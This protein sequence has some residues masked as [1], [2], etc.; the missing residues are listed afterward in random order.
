MLRQRIK[1]FARFIFLHSPLISLLGYYNHFR[2]VYR[3]KERSQSVFPPAP[4]KT[5]EY[6]PV[7]LIIH[8][9]GSLTRLRTFLDAIV[10]QLRDSDEMTVIDAAVSLAA[11]QGK[12]FSWS[13]KLVDSEAGSPGELLNAAIQASKNPLLVIAE[14]S[15]IPEAGFLLSLAGFLVNHPT[16]SF[17]T[18]PIE[19]QKR[20]SSLIPTMVLDEPKLLSYKNLAIWKK[21]WAQSGGF[22]ES[23]DYYTAWEI[24]IARIHDKTED[25]L[26]LPCSLAKLASTSSWMDVYRKSYREGLLGLSAESV[27]EQIRFVLPVI[28]WDI[29]SLVFLMIWPLTGLSSLLVGLFL[30]PVFG[31]KFILQ[32]AIPKKWHD[33]FAYLLAGWMQ[34]VRFFA[35]A[36]GVIRRKDTLKKLDSELI[37]QMRAIVDNHPSMQ[38]IVLF[39]PMVDWSYMFQRYQQM[40]RQFAKHGYLVF[41]RTDNQLSDAFVG[42][43]QVEPY[44]F[45]TP[46]P[47]ETFSEIEP[48]LLYFNSPWL[49][50]TLDCFIKPIVIYDH[51]DDIQVSGGRVADHQT[52]LDKAAVVLASSALLLDEDRRVRSDVLF[53]PNA[54]DYDLVI[55][56][57]PREEELPPDDLQPILAKNKPVVGYTG[58]LARWF[59]YELLTET[60]NRSPEW[61]FVLI[62]TDYDHSLQESKL[63]HCS[64]VTWLG[65]KSYE[66]LFRYT[67]R[68]N[69]TII[70]FL[71]N[72]V[73]L[74]TSPIKLYEY[75]ACQKPV[76]S[77]ALPECK[78]YNEVFI[79]TSASE[80]RSGIQRAL[81]AGEDPAYL[82]RISQ[83]AREN[84]WE[85]RLA[86][87]TKALG[88]NA[89]LHGGRI[90][91]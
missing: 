61:E 20:G 51:C 63:L 86:S 36:V 64:N 65:I 12:N 89:Q 19:L 30:L 43:Q 34:A 68:F 49:A 70:P 53:L 66:V 37:H 44:L 46:A 54:V 23:L 91:F 45:V 40:A 3:L 84:T 69:A 77:T 42:F 48:L 1:S 57:A 55:E 81:L 10:E 7:S 33:L 2:T 8:G 87:I 24:F 27:L 62:G 11:L 41:Y 9:D 25:H 21:T 73:T 72:D 35:Y 74:A 71:V 83:V 28:C 32:K 79:G 6:P 17:A 5:L 31:G 4:S 15:I 85:A 82:Q 60:C 14:T 58:A 16:A 52:L 90:E 13:V 56:N 50:Q 29:I 78:K 22:P 59:N 26:I 38:G 88:Q 76:V 47:L 67:W 75:F 18:A 80:F 39:S